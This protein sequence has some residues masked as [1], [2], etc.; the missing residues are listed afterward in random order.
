[1]HDLKIYHQQSSQFFLSFLVFS[2]SWT[3]CYSIKDTGTKFLISNRFEQYNFFWKF[4]LT[5]LIVLLL[6]KS[7]TRRNVT[8]KFVWPFCSDLDDHQISSFH[9]S[10][11]PKVFLG[12]GVLKTSSKFAGKHPCQ[13][14]ISIKLL[15][16]H[17]S[18]WVFC[19]K[20]AAY[21]QDA[22]L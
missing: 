13:S 15:C 7:S 1:M 20:F 19:C 9:R 10:S 21:F 5:L 12:K 22:F 16:N 17:T 18:T 4:P 11:P 8:S 6:L 2:C 3:S 14:M